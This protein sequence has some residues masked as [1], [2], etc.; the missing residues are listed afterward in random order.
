MRT[1]VYL[2][3]LVQLATATA[4][5]PAP[6]PNAA[7]T[8]RLKTLALELRAGMGSDRFHGLVDSLHT[9]ADRFADSPDPAVREAA[10]EGRIQ[11]HRFA[12][13]DAVFR[14]VLADAVHHADTV[15]ELLGDRS[16]TL[17]LI[18]KRSSNRTRMTVHAEV[19]DSARLCLLRE[20]DM[21]ISRVLGDTLALLDSY[22]MMAAFQ[23]ISDEGEAL[24][25]RCVA[26]GSDSVAM[27]AQWYLGRMLW[28]SGRD[29]E[30]VPHVLASRP[31]TLDADRN[32]WLPPMYHEAL[33]YCYQKLDRPQMALHHFD[34]CMQVSLKGGLLNWYCTCMTDKAHILTLL[35]DVDAA[36]R[37]KR[38]AFDTARTH[39]LLGH[40]A[41]QGGPVVEHLR[42]IGRW[43]VALEVSDAYHAA[44]DSMNN[45]AKGRELAGALF[46]GQMRTDSLEHAAELAVR[47]AE[48][49]RQRSLRNGAIGG[50][51]LLGLCAVVFL[52]QRVR[53]AR[54]KRRC[55][56]LLLNILPAEVA[57]EL[58]A[59]GS[60]EARH[61][62]QA[63]I[64]FT[65][66][67]G[68]T[69]MSE[70]L[71]PQE[72][73]E[74][75]DACFKAFDGIITTRGIEKIKTIGDAYMAAG[76]LQRHTPGSV[77]DVVHAALDMQEFMQRR[78][79]DRRLVG[80]PAFDMR[81]GIHT[82]PVVAGIVGVKKFQYDIWGDTVN[83]AS[84]MESS[85]EVGRVNISESTYREIAAQPGW[86]FTPRGKVSAKGKG[87]LEMYFVRRSQPDG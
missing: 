83:T 18:I 59:T 54:E 75:L 27:R 73:V 11:Y 68:F 70:L 39:G 52:F 1:L 66:F 33:G 69:E 37:L 56:E 36:F 51:A 76:G 71:T 43:R 87:E 65:D 21:R 10:A 4:Q 63:T 24:A 6:P 49:S 80:R 3:A 31:F 62:E 13:W 17:A 77:S 7:D 19:D 2:F 30:A 57:E 81:V 34:S 23:P 12:A 53:I 64:L 28:S 61:I 72:L 26:H 46:L 35:G 60:S 86:A 50:S 48:V 15:D 84:R 85:G 32:A 8:V 22:V 25:R 82:G 40:V 5:E 44:K 58:K 9:L 45:S 20:E 38:S 42:S 55:D 47:N 74:E 14:S 16:D 29:E 41:S 67:K 79:H 78:K